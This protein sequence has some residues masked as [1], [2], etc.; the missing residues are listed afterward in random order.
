MADPIIR[1]TAEDN[2]SKGINSVVRK[3]QW[4]DRQLL[5]S[6]K[7]V[8]AGMPSAERAVAARMKMRNIDYNQYMAQLAKQNAENERLAATMARTGRTGRDAFGG[9]QPPLRNLTAGLAGAA[10]GVLSVGAAL[11][12]VR[13]G[14]MGYATL[15]TQLRLVQNQTGMT[16]AEV[17]A[18]GKSM[19]KVGSQVGEST[20]TMLS[21][22]EKLR[23]VGH[24][25]L[26]RR[27]RE[28]ISQAGGHRQG[29]GR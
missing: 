18:L 26:D 5:A 3:F 11:E 7:A 27:G 29:Y 9:M 24:Q 10:A 21:A 8:T 2:T 20:S 19:S 25:P 4:M 23:R 6:D 14:F 28:D 15:D 22:F 16:R 17:D 1:I 12:F 13:R